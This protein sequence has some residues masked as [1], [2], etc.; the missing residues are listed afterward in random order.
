M[1]AI[2]SV[3]TPFYKGNAF[4][5]SLLKS[6]SG[7]KDVLPDEWEI[8]AIIVN[9]SPT[10]SVRIKS[11][12]GFPIHIY[13]NEINVGIQ[14]TRVNGLKKANGEWIIFLDQD[15][16]LNPEGFKEQI[17]L[18]KNADMVIGNSIYEYPD[19]D[20]VMYRNSRVMKYYMR[21]TMFIKIRN[22]IPSPGECLIK[23]ES[24][25]TLWMEEPM[26]INGADDWFLWL[27]MFSNNVRIA[28]N[29]KVV[30]IHHLVGN[31]NLS[32][33]LNKMYQSSIEMCRILQRNKSLSDNELKILSG[34]IEYKYRRD[35]SKNKVAIDIRNGTYCINNVIYKVLSKI[36]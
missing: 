14:Q 11:N 2:I 24:I 12:Y 7:V 16:E 25:P 9:D 20:S 15:D 36:L 3:I 13:N 5:D 10:E 19:H 23:K 31:S 27:L 28:V 6:I 21:K 1:G 35:M 22:L 33:D 8:E 26:K 34:T 30:Y 32:L 4:M 18:T 29:D 17:Q